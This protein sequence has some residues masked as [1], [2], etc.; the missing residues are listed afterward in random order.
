M[1][2]YFV[3]LMS[4]CINCVLRYTKFS[5]IVKY[6]NLALMVFFLIFGINNADYGAY[7]RAYSNPEWYES[8]MEFGY[9]GMTKL[10]NAIGFYNYIT[11]LIILGVLLIYTMVK[12]DNVVISKY[13]MNDALVLFYPLSYIFFLI[14]IRNS[15]MILFVINFV[16]AVYEKKKIKAFFFAALSISFQ[17]FAVVYILGFA[18]CYIV[19][20]RNKDLNTIF[21]LKNFIIVIALMLAV[22]ILKNEI[23]LII[24]KIPI[25]LVATKINLYITREYETGVGIYVWSILA[26]ID[27]VVFYYMGIKKISMEK[28]SLAIYLYPFLLFGV[29]VSIFI[30]FFNE[31]SRYFRDMF[32]FKAV[33][34]WSLGNLIPKKYHRYLF[35]YVLITGLV[36]ML[37]LGFDADSVFRENL[38]F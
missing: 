38:L 23:I 31:F 14:Q 26:I 10:L 7:V 13:R 4:L 21:K 25:A 1:W 32:L 30:V 2:I 16:L 37:G 36:I 19:I 22:T 12:I 33:L 24:S 18:L 20:I 15:F 29:F 34:W 11:V 8:N 17:Y 35:L 9:I 3:I 27:I 5:M 6:N 28:K